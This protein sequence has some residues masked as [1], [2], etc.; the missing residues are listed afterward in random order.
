MH[1]SKPKRPSKAS[2][3]SRKKHSPLDDL[4][5]R[6]ILLE[7]A[8]KVGDDEVSEVVQNT[9]KIQGKAKKGPLAEFFD[10]IL[11]LLSMVRDYASGSYREIPFGTIAAVVGALI[12]VLSPVDLIP[13]FIPGIGYV[14]DAAVIA[15]CLKL[16]KGDVEKYKKGQAF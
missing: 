16:V 13:D 3:K 7:A 11:V 1:A 5:S 12:Y 10:D 9:K 14:D 6:S 8:S 15:A 2:R 4:D